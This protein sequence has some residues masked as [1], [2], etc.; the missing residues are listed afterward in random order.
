MTDKEV[1]RYL[2]LVDRRLYILHHSGIDWRPEYGLELDS[3]D[4]ELVELR[5]VI[6][7]EH[8]SRRKLIK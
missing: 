4:R 8:A 2:E 1:S 7:V 5:K 3:I 6:E